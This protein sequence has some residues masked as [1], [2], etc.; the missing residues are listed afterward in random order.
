MNFGTIGQN[1]FSKVCIRGLLDNKTQAWASE[2][3]SADRLDNRVYT[4]CLQAA[5]LLFFCSSFSSVYINKYIYEYT[6]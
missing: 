1:N 3:L 4:T 6:R 5:F 2:E